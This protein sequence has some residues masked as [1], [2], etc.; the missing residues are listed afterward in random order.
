[1]MSWWEGL[2]I[3]GSTAVTVPL[4]I[5][6]AAWL[7]AGRSWRL[8][9]SWCLLFGGA[10]L[11]VVL[12]KM[13]YIGWGIGIEEVQFGGLSGHAMRACAVY[14][15]RPLQCRTWPF[16]PE[17][18]SSEQAWNHSAKRCHGM[19]AAGRTFSLNQI[20]AIR[21]A[22]LAMGRLGGREQ[23]YGSDA[24]VLF[25][26]EALPGVAEADAAPVAHDVAHEVRRLLALPAPDPPAAK[27]P[28]EDRGDDEAG[29]R[30]EPV[31]RL[32][33]DRA[34]DDAEE[35]HE[36][37]HPADLRHHVPLA[38]VGLVRGTEEVAPR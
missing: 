31:A 16:W 6:I 37:E 7:L 1:M 32:V 13:A 18:L 9:L 30:E 29:E 35:A 25:V 12:T 3:V 28:H 36:D 4:S 26:H 23:G 20:H 15:V 2:S 17:N 11:L 24:D 10:M 5:A 27:V 38:V 19:N 22:I 14:P 21:D 8:S 33:R 34:E